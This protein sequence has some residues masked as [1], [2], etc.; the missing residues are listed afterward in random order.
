VLKSIPIIIISSFSSSLIFCISIFSRSRESFFFLCSFSSFVVGYTLA[1]LSP[2]HMLCS[3]HGQALQ[4]QVSKPD[5]VL[6]IIEDVSMDFVF[7]PFALL[8]SRLRGLFDAEL[9]SNES[10]TSK[11]TMLDSFGTR[12]WVHGWCPIWWSIHLGSS[13]SIAQQCKKWNGLFS[14]EANL[15]AAREVCKNEQWE[16]SCSYEN[17]EW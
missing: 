8:K 9:P 3:G 17:W 10:S 1:I 6:Q 13:F 15:L 14:I 16:Q 5:Q 11:S 7:L 4:R 2:P 12:G